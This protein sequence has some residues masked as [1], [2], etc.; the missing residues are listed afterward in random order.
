MDIKDFHTVC[1]NLNER[2]DRWAESQEEF[3][4]ANIRVARFSGIKNSNPIV[5]CALSHFAVLEQCL[6]LNMNAVVFEDDIKF[7]PKIVGLGD[8]LNALDALQ[9]DMLYLGANIT[10]PIYRVS[11]LFGKLTSAQSTHAYLVNIRFIPFILSHSSMLGKH[12]DLIY[13]ENIVP[14]NECFITIPMLATQRASF[15]DIENRVVNY[16][17]MEERYETHLKKGMKDGKS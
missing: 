13:S 10:S 3:S 1:I 15:S 8:Y 4:K 16:D 11:N 5:G 17:W 9:W 12:M 6:E 14:H 2:T 7:S